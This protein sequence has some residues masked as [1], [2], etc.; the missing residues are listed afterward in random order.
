MKKAQIFATTVLLAMG[1]SSIATTASAH[2][3][4]WYAFA[5]ATKSHSA[6]QSAQSRYGGVIHDVDL[7]NSK[8]AGQ[9]WW[10]VSEGPGSK[11]QARQ[12]RRDFKRAGAR[13]AYIGNR[14]FSG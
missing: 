10:T 2:G 11:A 13:K 9:G 6:A 7:S 14:C 4:G 3:C 5:L 12:W 8:N 1:G